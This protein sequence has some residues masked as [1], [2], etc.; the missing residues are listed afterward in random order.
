MPLGRALAEW[1]DFFILVGT[2]GATLVA[3]LFVAASLGV[4]YLTAE[5]AIGTRTFMTPVVI[6]F[7]AVFFIS[8]VSLVPSMAPPFF[9][10]VI[11]IAALVGIGVSI[12]VT[13]MVLTSGMT[14]D[15]FDRL[16]YGI[17][18][19]TGYIAILA[20]AVLVCFEKEWAIDVLGG[21]L[22]LLAIVNIRNGWDLTLSMVRRHARPE[23]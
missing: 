4:G 15:N 17:L 11:G 20:A 14:R 8:A 19:A 2:A 6:H 10:G 23:R 21:A 18:P 12:F 1:H 13:Y 22:L 5:G 7:A 16:A 9:A 3:L